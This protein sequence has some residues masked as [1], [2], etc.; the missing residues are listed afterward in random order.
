M[1]NA[2]EFTLHTTLKGMVNIVAVLL[3]LW[4]LWVQRLS[5]T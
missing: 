2:I 1:L 4:Y 5:A 3:R